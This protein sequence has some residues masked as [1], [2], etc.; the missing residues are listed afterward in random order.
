MPA[1]GV[2]ADF[3]PRGQPRGDPGHAAGPFGKQ[4]VI[5]IVVTVALPL[6]PL[7]LTMFPARRA[8]QEAGRHH[9]L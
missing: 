5:P 9:P 2:P 6:L 4:V 1:P 3:S 7:L 8:A